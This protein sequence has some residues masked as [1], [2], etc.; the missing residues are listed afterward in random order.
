[1]MSSLHR[2]SAALLLLLMI[3]LSV[4]AQCQDGSEWDRARAALIASQPTAMA[5]AVSRWQMLTASD[6]FGFSDYAGFVLAYPGFP[7]EQKLRLSAEKALD[8][9]SADQG[10][11]IAFFDR[12]APLTNP[13]RAQYGLALAA[14]G[15]PE[16]TDA[17]RAAWRGG[18]MSDTA[19]QT[20]LASYGARFN[21]ADFDARSDALL[22]D[23]NIVQ[24]T[25]VLYR[26]S[27]AART[28]AQARLAMLEGNLTLSD[29]T[30]L[31]DPGYDYTRA[32]ML[33]QTRQADAAA[34]LLATRP[35]LATV[36]FDARKW[37]NLQ[38]TVARGGAVTENAVRI[39]ERVDDS[40]AAG[41][42]IS[43]LSFPI[44]DDYTSLTWLGGTQALWIL[45]DPAR[46][47]ALFYRYGAAGRTPQTRAK[48]FYWAGRALTQAGQGDAA[49]RYFVSAAAFP[50][51]FY[52][53]LALE[54]LGRPLPSLIDPPHPT[55]SPAKRAAFYA[56]PITQA[57]TEV[58]RNADWQTTI[59]FFREISAQALTESDRTL[60]AELARYLGRRDLGVVLGQAAGDDQVASFRDVSFPLI[61]TPPETDWT[62]VHAI[63][64]QES[65]F[66]QNAVSRT[67]A[68]GL[69]QLMP[70]TAQDQ[71]RKLGMEYSSSRLTNPF[72]NM[73]L[74]DAVFS[75]LMTVYNG[76]YPLAVAAYNSGP[77]NVN[78]WLRDNGDPRFGT[79]AWVD[80]IE[81]I[82]FSETR[83]YVAHV[84]ENAV[85]YEALYPA[86]ARYRGENPASHFLAKRTPG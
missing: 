77:G 18:T 23:G 19:E 20:I 15:R 33:S 22:W 21:T 31:S 13:G 53:M 40:F 16:A 46:A 74:G 49:R 37:I 47:A 78:K 27:P 10:Q 45:H 69:M 42:N 56:R 5:Q 70:G 41:T 66:S 55:P 62:M 30:L 64:R 84:I 67:G 79:I 8:R 58:A 61:P 11:I 51:Q 81:Q 9:G 82:P 24:A 76:S 12:F 39:A 36:P 38:L 75:H 68:R 43:Q 83:N 73:E 3:C 7:D 14:L 59:R 4:P 29:G 34:S 17:M 54:R 32:R 2:R 48:G 63:T 65:Q 26:L 71:A 50:D 72:Y 44:R 60:V 57:V 86:H 28:I 52:G 80:W 85:V 35:P 6:S 1:V 25:N